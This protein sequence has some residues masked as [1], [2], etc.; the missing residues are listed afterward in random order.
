MC[1]IDAAWKD[2]EFFSAVV[3]G[4]ATG[5]RQFAVGGQI[6]HIAVEV[7]ALNFVFGTRAAN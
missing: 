4:F 3:R 1:C 7:L 6:F 5:C 2:T